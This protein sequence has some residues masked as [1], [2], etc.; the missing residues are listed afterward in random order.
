MNNH[1]FTANHYEVKFLG[2][3]ADTYTSSTIGISTLCAEG[4]SQS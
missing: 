4:K 2:C 3:P 1:V